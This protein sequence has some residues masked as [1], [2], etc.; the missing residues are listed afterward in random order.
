MVD[1]VVLVVA[2]LW[3]VST[4]AGIR[5]VAVLP[6]L[7]AATD[8]ARTERV[9]AIVPAR[10][11]AARI[12]G[13]LQRLRS[14]R[15]LDV[16]VV[17]VDDRSTDETA[18]ILERISADDDYVSVIHVTDLP[19]GWLGKNHA[20]HVAAESVGD[21]ADWLLFADADAWM[22]RDAVARALQHAD[23]TEADHV[24]LVPGLTETRAGGRGIVLTMCLGFFAQAAWVNA[25]RKRAYLGVGAFNLVRASAYRDAGGHDALR[26]EVLDDLRLGKAL[27]NAGFRTRACFGADAVECEWITTIRS[28]FVLTEKNYFAALDFS[29]VRLVL[30]VGL[31][32]AAWTL[33]TI[34]PLLSGWQGWCAFA[35]LWGH[36]IPSAM[37]ARRYGW[38]A[39]YG[40]LVPIVL[41]IVTAGM[42]WSAVQTLRRGG[43]RWRG[44]TY[45][46]A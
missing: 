36:A 27:R 8:A 3:F 29:V 26:G 10:D 13:T 32:V 7:A 33:A 4:L 44:T 40:L 30:I 19:D 12:E 25:D 21:G 18:E 41:P 39:G 37:T 43:V 24:C 11:E 23:A 1:V 34:G 46:R 9:V 15:H 31:T 22:S 28:F 5:R 20:C 45:P 6:D 16:R 35:G 38:S 2:A 42:V 14:Q 17:A